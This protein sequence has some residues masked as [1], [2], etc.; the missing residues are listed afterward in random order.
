MTRLFAEW[1]HNAAHSA[2]NFVD[3]DLRFPYW[4]G[5]S[6]HGSNILWQ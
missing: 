5:I 2:H 6:P 3:V 1:E 4:I